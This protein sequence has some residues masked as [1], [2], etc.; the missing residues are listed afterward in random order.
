M[1]TIE[2]KLIASYMV[3]KKY[4]RHSVYK[5]K[6]IEVTPGGIERLVLD[7]TFLDKDEAT[8]KAAEA[9]EKMKKGEYWNDDSKN[10]IS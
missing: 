10:S 3:Y 8:A 7:D 5:P 9:I 1:S 2:P 6:V 4:K